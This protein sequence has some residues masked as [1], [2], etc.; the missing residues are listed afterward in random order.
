[1][2]GS[3]TICC[4]ARHWS[5]IKLTRDFVTKLNIITLFNLSIKFREA[6]RDTFARHMHLHGVETAN[7]LFVLLG[8]D[9]CQLA[10]S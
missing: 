10:A 9:P 5:D 6:S 8:D 1:M 4:D 2:V 7:T 3:M